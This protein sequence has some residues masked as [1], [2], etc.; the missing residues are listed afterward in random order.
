VSGGSRINFSAFRFRHDVGLGLGLQVCTAGGMDSPDAGVGRGGESATLEYYN[1][2]LLAS[3]TRLDGKEEK[4]TIRYTYTTAAIIHSR[5][6]GICLPIPS[7]REDNI[8]HVT[9][10]RHAFRFA[11]KRLTF[12]LLLNR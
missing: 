3:R 11:V 9:V 5:S 7:Q 12:F 4:K 6:V 8:I 2:V 10:D 1:L